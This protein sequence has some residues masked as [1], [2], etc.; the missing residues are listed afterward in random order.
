MKFRS[1][2]TEQLKTKLVKTISPGWRVYQQ[3]TV[4]LEVSS[5]WTQKTF[6]R[7]F[8]ELSNG[9]KF[10]WIRLKT[11][12]LFKVER[13]G[14]NSISKR[15]TP[16]NWKT[17]SKIIAPII[18]SDNNRNFPSEIIIASIFKFSRPRG[19]WIAFI[20]V[21][22]NGRWRERHLLPIRHPANQIRWHGDPQTFP[23]W[24]IGSKSPSWMIQ[25]DFQ[26]SSTS[27]LKR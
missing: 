12:E 22:Q 24:R 17:L 5:K 27:D 9:I 1:T 4:K 25:T 6:E 20:T 16:I 3:F 2:W 8:K 23:L 14:S 18:H 11:T 19:A 26:S 21:T 13:R 15:L 7:A 10:N